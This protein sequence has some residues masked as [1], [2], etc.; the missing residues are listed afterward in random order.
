MSHGSQGLPGLSDG[1]VCWPLLSTGGSKS[2]L[3]KYNADAAICLDRNLM[4]PDDFKNL[5]LIFEKQESQG[6]G[7]TPSGGHGENAAS[8]A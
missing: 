1:E 8:K 3:V 7:N 5:G 2:G 4:A 6:K